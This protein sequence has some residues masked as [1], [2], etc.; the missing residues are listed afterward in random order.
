VCGAIQPGA[1]QEPAK[2]SATGVSKQQAIKPDEKKTDKPIINQ[3]ELAETAK[4]DKNSDVRREAIKKITDQ[5]LL[6]D[7]AINACDENNNIWLDT[8]IAYKKVKNPHIL[9]E[10]AKK[11]KDWSVRAGCCRRLEDTEV[12]HEIANEDNNEFVRKA[13]NSKLRIIDER[14]SIDHE[15][16]FESLFFQVGLFARGETTGGLYDPNSYESMSIC[17][18]FVS[19]GKTAAQV[20]KSYL[21][22]CAAGKEKY[23]WWTNASLVVDCISLAAGDSEADKLMLNSW[24]TQIVNASSNIAEYDND[25]RRYAQIELDVLSE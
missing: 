7:I 20:M 4:N 16:S 12:L 18:K 22:A 11:A 25:V 14:K 5:D 21:M 10:I 23:G 8:I 6:S 19:Y 15:P 9:A 24:L 1:A 13:A 17:D 2:Q 3:T